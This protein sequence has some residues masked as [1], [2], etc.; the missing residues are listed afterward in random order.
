MI[1]YKCELCLETFESERS[2][3]DARDKAVK[4]HGED[5]D[6]GESIVCHDCFLK[7]MEAN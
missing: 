7:L 4:L 3:D 5:L 6:H 1:T 2:E